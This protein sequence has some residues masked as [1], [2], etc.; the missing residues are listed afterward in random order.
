[1]KS[2]FLIGGILGFA[3]GLV[4]S[5]AQASPWPACLWHACL[6]AYVTGVLFRW[7]GRAWRRNLQE[8]L[9]ARHNAE[10]AAQPSVFAKGNKT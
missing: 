7:W 6:A 10:I 8:V 5:W 4:F 1:M 3:L 9:E 2:I